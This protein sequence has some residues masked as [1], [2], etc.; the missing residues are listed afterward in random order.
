MRL[1]SLYNLHAR[2]DPL[3]MRSFK[4]F[5]FTTTQ[6]YLHLSRLSQNTITTR[7]A[8]TQCCERFIHSPGVCTV[9]T[10]YS[11]YTTRSCIY[12]CKQLICLNAQT[13]KNLYFG[14]DKLPQMRRELLTHKNTEK[15][16]PT[17]AR[18]TTASWKDLQIYAG[19]TL[20]RQ[21]LYGQL[22]KM[23]ANFN[24]FACFISPS[25]S[26]SPSSPF[27]RLL[28]RLGALLGLCWTHQSDLSPI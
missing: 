7:A 18:E 19:F 11:M 21:Y 2:P 4:A 6:R 15:T 26:P 3:D 8:T 27:L 22:A 25:T 13:I 23:L 24:T 12:I 5:F 1:R 17:T 10:I 28:D 14:C 16:K 9:Y 20:L